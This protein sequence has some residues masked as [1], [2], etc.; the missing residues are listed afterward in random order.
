MKKRLRYLILVMMLVLG[1][2]NFSDMH[3]NAKSINTITI[4]VKNNTQIVIPECEGTISGW[5]VTNKGVVKIVQ[6]NNTM[7]LKAVKLGQSIIT[8]KTSKGIT[9]K[10]YVCVIRDTIVKAYKGSKISIRIKKIR[11]GNHNIVLQVRLSNGTKKPV[12]YEC[13]YKLQRKYKKK[14][15]TKKCMADIAGNA[16]A[17]S[18]KSS[19]EFPI[20]LSNYYNNLKKGTYRLLFLIDGKEKYV[21]FKL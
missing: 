13:G 14:W 17:V 16:Y 18:G 10:Y 19:V 11:K 4:I 15:K 2:W 8:V 12:S 3:V 21:K 5:N 6:T 1:I 7:K 9:R 20:L